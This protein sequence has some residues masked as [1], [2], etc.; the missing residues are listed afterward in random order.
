MAMWPLRAMPTRARPHEVT[1]LF[2]V[3][4]SRR[5]KA[6]LETRAMAVRVWA[7][8]SWTAAACDPEGVTTRSEAAVPGRW[9]TPS[10]RGL[11]TT[12]ASHRLWPVRRLLGVAQDD[13][14]PVDQG[15][16]VAPDDDESCDR[17]P[18]G[19]QGRG[20]DEAGGHHG[21][22][23]Q[24]ERCGGEDELGQGQAEQNAA[25]RPVGEF[26]REGKDKVRQGGVRFRGTG[27]GP[28]RDTALWCGVSRPGGGDG[29]AQEPVGEGPLAKGLLAAAG[30]CAGA[31][32]GGPSWVLRG[33]GPVPPEPEGPE[34]PDGEDPVL[35]PS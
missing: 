32:C 35:P 31:P 9:S 30:P 34:G 6:L 4:G 10:V 21:G 2:W 1:L 16:A 25:P 7:W 3:A 11:D 14:R 26:D 15:P 28:G 17:G 19:S 33:T 20:A 8:G 18:Q 13:R 27:L 12:R 24:G 23:E 22:Q 29:S 5:A